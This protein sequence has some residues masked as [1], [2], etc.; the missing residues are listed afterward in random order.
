[1]VIFDG[2]RGQVYLAEL[3]NNYNLK[4]ISRVVDRR[5]NVKNLSFQKLNGSYKTF[6]TLSDETNKK[7]LVM[8]QLLVCLLNK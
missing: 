4:R 6:F 2:N 1:M 3:D 8:K 7:K 5:I